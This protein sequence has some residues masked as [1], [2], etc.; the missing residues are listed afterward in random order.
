LGDVY[1]PWYALPVTPASV[2]NTRTP[3]G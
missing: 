2:Y 3:A 1:D